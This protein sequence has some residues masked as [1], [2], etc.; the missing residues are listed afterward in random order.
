MK[1]TFED[2]RARTAQVGK[3]PLDF[4]HRTASNE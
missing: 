4:P 1:K 2:F 3:A